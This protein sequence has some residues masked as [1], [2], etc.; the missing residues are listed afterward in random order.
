MKKFLIFV[1]FALFFAGCVSVENF[2]EPQKR[3]EKE[4]QMGEKML[5][6]FKK[7]D[8]DGYILPMIK[9]SYHLQ[10]EC[11][12]ICLQKDVRYAHIYNYTNLHSVTK[13]FS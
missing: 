2:A 10:R 12:Y 7:Q 8:F 1:F 13:L 9:N 6:A 3:I 5:E 11:F 4:Q